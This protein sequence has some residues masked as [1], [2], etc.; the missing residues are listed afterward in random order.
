MKKSNMVHPQS[1]SAF[2]TRGWRMFS[3]PLIANTPENIHI[4]SHWWPVFFRQLLIR[5][6][7]ICNF[8]EKLWDLLTQN[9][10]N[11]IGGAMCPHF[12]Q[13]AFSPWK[14]CLD[15]SWFIHSW[16]SFLVIKK[17]RAHCALT[18]KLHSKASHY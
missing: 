12:F 9:F 17:V 2:L 11:P 15:F 4:S 18:L 6:C 10:L 7:L 13:M 5:V 8:L 1:I 3:T 14:I 16:F